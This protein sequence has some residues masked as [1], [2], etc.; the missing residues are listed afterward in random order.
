MEYGTIIKKEIGNKKITIYP[1]KAADAP[2]IYLNAV[3]EEEGIKIYHALLQCECPN[4]TLVTISGLDWNHEMAPWDA[5]PVFSKNDTPFT[6]GADAYLKQLTEE[7][8]PC[9]ECCIQGRVSWRG[10]A[11]YSLAGLF[12]VYAMYQT[13]HFE[14]IA[15]ISGSLWFPDFAAY[16]LFNKPIKNPKRLYFSLGDAESRT[17]NPYLKTVQSCT[18][19]LVAFYQKQ[20]I[21]T[22]LCMNAGGHFKDTDIRTAAGILWLLSELP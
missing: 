19:K 10:L 5:A 11:G 16:A 14:R 13:A 9:A 3:S 22:T 6:Q 7:I 8:I 15:S 4:F 20:G 12:A 1:G 2:V 17:K 18:E 21:N